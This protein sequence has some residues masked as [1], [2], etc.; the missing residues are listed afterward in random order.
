VLSTED[1]ATGV[2]D[3]I[4]MRE[5]LKKAMVPYPGMYV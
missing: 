4:K 1:I 2:K 3:L 5:P